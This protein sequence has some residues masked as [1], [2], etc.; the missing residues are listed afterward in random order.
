MYSHYAANHTGVCLE[1]EPNGDPA[2]KDGEKVEYISQR[3]RISY[4]EGFRMCLDKYKRQFLLTKLRQ[5]EYEKEWR[6][7]AFPFLKD[8]N[9]IFDGPF[10]L[11]VENRTKTLSEGTLKGIILG[12]N[13]SERNIQFIKELVNLKKSNVKLYQAR[14]DP[15]EYKINIL[16]I[17]QDRK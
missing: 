11:P 1:Y 16:P 9:K 15:M 17:E 10:P 14:Q 4:V 2:F 13:M 3:P 7:V 5:W 6:I 8:S 12:C